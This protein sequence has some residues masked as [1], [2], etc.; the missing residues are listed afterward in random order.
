M[1]GCQ[2]T[3]ACIIVS[4][5]TDVTQRLRAERDLRRRAEEDTQGQRSFLVAHGCTAVQGYLFA[6]LMR[7]EY[8]LP[9][10]AQQQRQKQGQS[11][12]RR[13]RG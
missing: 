1:L 12:Q 8:T 9:W 3:C 13:L 6:W 11:D 2:T 4:I 7:A 5:R 10:L